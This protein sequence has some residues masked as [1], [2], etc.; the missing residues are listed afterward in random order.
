MMDNQDRNV[1]T[2]IPNI[3]AS[4]IA[5]GLG[6]SFIIDLENNVYAFGFNDVGQLGL[7]DIE[8]RYVPTLIPNIKAKQ[9]AAGSGYSFI[10][11]FRTN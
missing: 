7:G 10:I 5:A 3:K 6:H 11:G 1:P 4:Q 2:L 9:V 8:K